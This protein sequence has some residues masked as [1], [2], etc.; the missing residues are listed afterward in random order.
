MTPRG[1]RTIKLCEDALT[2]DLEFSDQTMCFHQLMPNNAAAAAVL[3]LRQ[4][5]GIL[6]RPWIR[7]TKGS[8]RMDMVFRRDDEELDTL[9]ADDLL[10]YLKHMA[11]WG[12]ADV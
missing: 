11:P 1:L 12:D 3:E 7:Y 10:T 9:N 8:G 2:Q 4:E 5:T 6:F